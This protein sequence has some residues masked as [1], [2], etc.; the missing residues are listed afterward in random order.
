MSAEILCPKGDP[1]CTSGDDEC[2]DACELP[3]GKRWPITSIESQTYIDTGELPD[4]GA[5][6]HCDGCDQNC[7][8]V[9]RFR[10]YVEVP[11]IDGNGYPQEAGWH[12]AKYCPECRALADSA[13]FPEI[14]QVVRADEDDVEPSTP[15]VSDDDKHEMWMGVKVTKVARAHIDGR[16]LRA[17]ED[18]RDVACSGDSDD[19]ASARTLLN[20]VIAFLRHTNPPPVT[21]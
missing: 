17:L 3:E 12:D 9:L 20:E 13:E 1:D 15:I 5:F 14:T 21:A 19:E 8:N 4:A 18:V 2:H 16:H 11:R 6:D 10:I 7:E